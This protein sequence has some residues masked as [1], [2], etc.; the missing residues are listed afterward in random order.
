MKIILNEVV[1]NDQLYLYVA[2]FFILLLA[3]GIFRLVKLIKKI[4][5]QKAELQ[6][7]VKE[8]EEYLNKR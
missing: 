8:Y 4:R 6:K 3:F 1:F 5:K 2:I 7:L